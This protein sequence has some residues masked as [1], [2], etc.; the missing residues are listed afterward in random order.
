MKYTNIII[1]YPFWY[2]WIFIHYFR[3]TLYT[4]IIGNWI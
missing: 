2:Y 3:R 4:I 1:L